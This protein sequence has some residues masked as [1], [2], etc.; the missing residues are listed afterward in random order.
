MGG[1]GS[2]Y[3]KDD[4]FKDASD[5]LER[6]QTDLERRIEDAK[7]NLESQFEDVQSK[8]EEL[9][10]LTA[11][12]F[13]KVKSVLTKSEKEVKSLRAE[14][15]HANACLGKMVS[16]PPAQSLSLSAQTRHPHFRPN[17]REQGR[18]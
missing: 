12:S 11:Q 2:T 10:D 5:D 4:V 7:N 13:V 18:Q 1:G 8:Q 9:E 3:L 14:V 6:K 16:R 15:S 17:S